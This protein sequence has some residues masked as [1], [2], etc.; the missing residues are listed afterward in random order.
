MYRRTGVTG[1]M[2]LG[3]AKRIILGTIASVKRR[4]ARTGRQSVGLRGQLRRLGRGIR[5]RWQPP[6]TAAT[7]SRQVIWQ[8]KSVRIC[9]SETQRTCRA[10]ACNV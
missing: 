1:R 5:I 10:R 4:E 7:D 8:H 2:Y 3:I 9:C 6:S